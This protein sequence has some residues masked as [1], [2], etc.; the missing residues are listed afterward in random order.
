MLRTKLKDWLLKFPQHIKLPHFSANELYEKGMLFLN[1][2]WQLLVISIAALFLLYYPLGGLLVSN[3]D[4]NTTYDINEGHPEQSSTV[5]MESFII[6]REVN[7]KIWTPK[8]PFFYPSYFLDNMPNFQL[9]MFNGLSKFASSFAKR[10]APR[11]KDNEEESDLTAAAEL[12]R[13]PGTIWM[14]SSENKLLLSPSAN[15]QYRK[16]RRHLINYNKKLSNGELTFYKTPADLAYILNKTGINLNKSSEIL[17]NHIREESSS[18]WD[19]KAD[20]VFYYQQGKAYTYYLLLKALGN[21]YKEIIVN[22]ELY[23]EWTSLLKALE[24]AASVQ[25]F[26]VRNGEINSLT[27]P[28]HLSYLNMYINKAYGKISRIVQ[29]LKHAQVKQKEKINADRNSKNA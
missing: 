14:F 7:D 22:A 15:N 25:P 28:N 11:I 2:W 3:I 23:P 26:V 17:E 24:D 29:K 16:A 4:R 27:A 20:N 18:W 12:L 6:N 19:N 9:G 10:H 8:L 21:D 1:S 13:Y 5:E